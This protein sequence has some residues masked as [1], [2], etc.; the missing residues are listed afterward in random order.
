MN[1]RHISEFSL[2][3][4]VGRFPRF[5]NFVGFLEGSVISY[6]LLFWIL[7]RDSYFIFLILFVLALNIPLIILVGRI[8]LKKPK[9]DER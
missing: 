9:K 8:E 5:F 1:C 6:L 3:P 4:E 2:L 7:T